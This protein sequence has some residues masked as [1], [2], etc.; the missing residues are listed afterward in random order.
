M[1]ERKRDWLTP[2]KVAQR[3]ARVGLKVVAG[4][5]EGRVVTVVAAVVLVTLPVVLVALVL[6][7][8]AVA[9]VIV[10]V[11]IVAAAITISNSSS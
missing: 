4:V 2:A 5:A 3:E 8:I 11:V 10:A 9:V 6:V 1:V 7:A